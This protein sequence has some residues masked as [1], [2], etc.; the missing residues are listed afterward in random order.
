MPIADVIR[1]A[2]SEVEEYRR[3]S[4]RRLDDAYVGGGYVTGLAHM[5]AELVENGLAFSPPDVDVEIQSRVVGNQYLI[6]II[7]QGVGMTPEDL[8]KANA[9][10]RGEE[11]FL[12]APARFL[13]HYVVGQLARQLQVDVE[14][15]NSPVTG[16][17]ARVT[18]P[19]AAL[20]TPAAIEPTVVVPTAPVHHG[21]V[22]LPPAPAPVAAQL[23]MGIRPA[24]VVEYI[25]VA[26]PA[27]VAATALASAPDDV[28]RTRN[29]LRKRLPR[30]RPA[31]AASTARSAPEERPAP[32]DGSPEQLRDRLVSL[33]AGVHRGQ[34]ERSGQQHQQRENEGHER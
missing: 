33:R 18:L 11:H 25:T 9:R 1:A 21:S 8:A 26:D 22:P 2:I 31:P 34:T 16:I 20:A 19:P 7:D 17:T 10:L 3:V 15:V 6:A 5:I 4:L 14:L 29:G 13:G 30:T 12:M 24:P 28:E 32:V 27:P 23:S